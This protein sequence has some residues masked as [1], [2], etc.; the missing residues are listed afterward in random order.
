MAQFMAAFAELLKAVIGR[1]L[2]RIRDVLVG[3]GQHNCQ[4][5]L[6][7]LAGH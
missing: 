6:A 7:A 3:Y 1:D 5:V 4:L 2:A